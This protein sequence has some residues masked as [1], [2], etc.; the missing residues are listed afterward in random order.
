MVMEDYR[1]LDYA[2]S[3]IYEETSRLEQLCEGIGDT[4]YARITKDEAK[5]I[6]GR[7]INP[8]KIAKPLLDMYP[9]TL[10]VVGFKEKY[11]K[12]KENKAK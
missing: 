8:E 7:Y 11:G 10:K 2:I 12:A 1:A 5:E 6:I 9:D 4:Y 3:K